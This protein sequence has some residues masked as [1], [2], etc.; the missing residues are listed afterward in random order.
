MK[1]VQFGLMI[2]GIGLMAGCANKPVMPPIKYEKSIDFQVAKNAYLNWEVGKQ[3]SGTVPTH[4]QQ[5]G[6][7]IG[8][9]VVSAIDSV[10]RSNNPSRYTLSYGKAE[11][12][13]FMTS[14][15]D[16]LARNHV[17]KQVELIADSQ[18]IAPK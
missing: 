10:E 7:L 12:I 17:F 6:G 8:A 13:V 1:K 4:H 11:Q 14:L 15:R 3:Y 18:K 16:V 9:L 2:L 5:N